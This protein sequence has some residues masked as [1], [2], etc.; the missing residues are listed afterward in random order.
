MPK[1]IWRHC[2]T[3]H[4]Q[5]PKGVG[6]AHRS[7]YLHTMVAGLADGHAV[8]ERDRALV[9]G[10]DVPRQRLGSSFAALTHRG[11]PGAARPASHP[12]AIATL[13]DRHRITYTRHGAHRRHDLVAHRPQQPDWISSSCGPRSV[14]HRRRPN[15]SALSTRSA[16]RCS[17]AGDDRDLA[18]GDVLPP[19]G[20]RRRR[21]RLA[22]PG[23]SGNRAGCLARLQ[24]YFAD[25]G[26]DALH[27]G[28]T[29]GEV[30][31]RGPVGG[32]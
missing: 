27:D 5:G 14:A 7:L 12:A 25:D 8:S 16:S 3:W 23:T 29:S 13:I 28:M 17:R 4:H 9:V 24:W 2:Y 15:S 20:S 6:Y 32:H 11:R 19:T 18:D 21:P 10:A 22:Y 1:P 31:I 26:T 30:I